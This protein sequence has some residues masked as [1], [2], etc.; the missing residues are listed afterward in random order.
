VLGKRRGKGIVREGGEKGRA[1]GEKEREREEERREL[2]P[3]L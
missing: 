3:D 2:P 1:V